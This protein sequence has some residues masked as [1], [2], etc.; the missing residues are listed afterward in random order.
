MMKLFAPVLP[1]AL[2]PAQAPVS[3]LA[4]GL[5]LVVATVVSAWLTYA[6]WRIESEYLRNYSFFC[7]PSAYY[8]YNIHLHNYAREHGNWAAIQQ[9]LQFN[10][11]H[12]LRTIP[13]LI[14]A[15]QSL[16]RK[17]GHLWTQ[18]PFLWAFLSLL[19]CVAYLR[20]RNLLFSLSTT[21]V[22]AAC[23]YLYDPGVGL[24]AYWLDSTAACCLGSAALCLIGYHEQKRLPW[25]VAFG[26]F[27]SAT[28]LSRFSSA[29]YLLSFAT[30]AVPLALIGV[31]GRNSGKLLQAVGCLA[32]AALPGIAFVAN[33]YDFNRRYYQT[34]GFAFGAS[35]SQSFSWTMQAIERIVGAPVLV[36]LLALMAINILRMRAPSQ[37]RLQAIALWLPVS[38][39]A[40]VCLVVRAISGTHPLVYM[41]PALVIAAM[42]PVRVTNQRLFSLL[43][44]CLLAISTCGIANSY[45][46]SRKIAHSA[47]PEARLAKHCDQELARLIEERGAKS[48][49]QI[50]DETVNPHLE[51]YFRSGRYCSSLVIFSKYEAYLKGIYPGQDLAAMKESVYKKAKG[52]AQLIAVF[53]DPDDAIKSGA[54]ANSESAEIAQAVSAKIAADPEFLLVGRVDSPTGPLCVYQNLALPKDEANQPK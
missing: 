33:F 10:A 2:A 43:S 19:S 29:F 28:A 51:A 42:L 48:F 52:S 37:F 4:I 14:A 41:A 40:F 11:R 47:P 22:F 15:P 5:L 8:V 38:L 31:C 35:L 20:T 23:P 45:E 54:F 44:G 39:L 21:T 3:K 53:A 26:L 46:S 18:T 7:D 30:L 36:L 34:F 25:L 49:L 12:P 16:V 24:G 32:I 1:I 6:P 17:D 9:E 27:F 13:Y 50:N